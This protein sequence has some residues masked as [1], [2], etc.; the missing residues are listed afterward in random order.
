MEYL[1]LAKKKTKEDFIEW[2]KQKKE[3]KRRQEELKE[4]FIDEELEDIGIS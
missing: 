2:L 1:T 3:E 4:V